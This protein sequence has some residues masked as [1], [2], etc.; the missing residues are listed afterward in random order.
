MSTAI[1]FSEFWLTYQTIMQNAVIQPEPANFIALCLGERSATNN[2]QVKLVPKATRFERLQKSIEIL[3][4]ISRPHIKQIGAAQLCDELV[5]LAE[6]S[7]KKLNSMINNVSLG[8]FDVV[9]P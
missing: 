4:S 8:S 6:L 3:V 2:N 7:L 1:G 9:I 5:R